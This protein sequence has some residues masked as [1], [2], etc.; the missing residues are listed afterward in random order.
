MSRFDMPDAAPE[1]VIG[2]ALEAVG[3]GLSGREPIL[4]RKALVGPKVSARHA[5]HAVKRLRAFVSKT[6]KCVPLRGIIKQ[7]ANAIPQVRRV[8]WIKIFRRIL[9]LPAI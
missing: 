2:R 6:S 7:L 3:L 1:A 8:S 4:K 5:I 9:P